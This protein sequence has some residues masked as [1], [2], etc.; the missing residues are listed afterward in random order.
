MIRALTGVRTVVAEGARRFDELV[1][2]RAAAYVADASEPFV[3][4]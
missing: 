3:Q 2:P 4:L 1:D